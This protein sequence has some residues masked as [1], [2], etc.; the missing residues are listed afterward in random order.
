MTRKEKLLHHA[1]DV[2]S[3]DA[4]A[5]LAEIC[6]GLDCRKSLA[7][8]YFTDKKSLIREAYLHAVA[9]DKLTNGFLLAVKVHAQRDPA[10]A[11][12]LES[13]GVRAA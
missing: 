5:T 7:H 12:L 8:Y 10:L 1:I 13:H 11:A 6:V 2:L 4:L 3:T 9:F